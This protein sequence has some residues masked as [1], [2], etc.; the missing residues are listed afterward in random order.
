M[1]DHLPLFVITLIACEFH[2]V[3]DILQKWQ[4]ESDV[5]RCHLCSLNF[6]RLIIA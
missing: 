5:Q 3:T 2:N 6:L 1:Y 4:K